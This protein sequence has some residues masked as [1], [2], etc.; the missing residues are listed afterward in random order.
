MKKL[1]IIKLGLSLFLLIV[2]N[3]IIGQENEKFNDLKNKMKEWTVNSVLP[4]VQLFKKEIESILSK[5][6]QEELKSLQAK[7]NDLR[8]EMLNKR[9]SALEGM[10]DKNKSSVESSRNSIASLRKEQGELLKDLQKLMTPYA[11]KIKSIGEKYKPKMEVLN[12]EAKKIGKEWYNKY[13][14]G[15]SKKEKAFIK[16][17]MLKKADGVKYMDMKKKMRSAKIL[18]WDGNTE[19]LK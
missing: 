11:D 4:E 15:F 10:R 5:T 8:K 3:Q 7:A 2:T 16:Y 13:E 19:M 17:R 9:I 18:L 6:D 1:A 14:S 12:D